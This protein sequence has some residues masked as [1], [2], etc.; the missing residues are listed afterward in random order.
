L[1]F[2]TE[3]I[4]LDLTALLV[5]V[6]L[7]LTGLVQTEQALSGFSNPAVVTVWAMFILSTGLTRTGVSSQIGIAILRFAKQGGGRLVAV[8]MT[9][10]AL[11][12]AVMN[13]TGVAAMFLPITME[14]AKRTKQPASRLLLPMAQGC[15][16]GGLILLIGTAS[17]LVVRDAMREAGFTPLGIFDF[18]P[19]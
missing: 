9:V 19:G 8:L 18:A 7:V 4:R 10:T 5:L 13:N 17:N 11:L 16:L 6:I 12:S 2:V 1:L 14:I 3:I 15:L